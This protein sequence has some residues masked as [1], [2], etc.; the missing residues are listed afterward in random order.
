MVGTSSVRRGAQLL[1]HRPDLVIKNLRGNVETRLG[2][3]ERGEYDAVILAEAGVRRLG[4]TT[5]GRRLPFTPSPNQGAIAVTARADSPALPLLRSL[6][7]RPTRVEVDAE[8]GIMERAGGGCAVPLG[9]LVRYDGSEIKLEAEILTTDGGYRKA[10]SR[11]ASPE[12]LDG[13]TEEIGK[14]LLEWMEGLP[15]PQLRRHRPGG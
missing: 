5:K 1:W 7:H 14:E 3:L 9:V 2:K 8:R 10:F 11:R 6:D 13:A 12:G 4:L 15:E